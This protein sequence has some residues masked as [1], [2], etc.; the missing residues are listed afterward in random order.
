MRMAI[1]YAVIGVI[2]G[3]STSSIRGLGTYIAPA[4]ATHDPAGVF[5]GIAI[6][7]AF[8]TSLSFCRSG[9]PARATISPR[10]ASR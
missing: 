7:L 5:A 1:P 10:R 6:L 9:P 3:E 4:S 2:V 8:V